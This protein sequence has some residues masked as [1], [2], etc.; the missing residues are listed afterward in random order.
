[1]LEILKN[2]D[3]EEYDS[4]IEWLGEEFDPESFDKEAMNK[5]LLTEDYGCLELFD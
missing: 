5:M 4:F 2:P 3:H 1:M